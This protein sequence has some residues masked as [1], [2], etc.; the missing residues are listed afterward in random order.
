[1]VGRGRAGA[2]LRRN[3]EY[4]LRQRNSGVG[5]AAL[6]GVVQVVLAGRDIGQQVRV[7]AADFLAGSGSAHK[8]GQGFAGGDMRAL[9]FAAGLA[10]PSCRRAVGAG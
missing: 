3:D 1:M 10:V 9:W 2:S 6:S 5:M 7:L 4:R 8:T